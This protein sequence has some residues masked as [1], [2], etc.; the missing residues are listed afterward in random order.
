ME[1]HWLR[2]WLE[3]PWVVRRL[4]ALLRGKEEIESQER[5]AGESLL[6]ETLWHLFEHPGLVGELFFQLARHV[7]KMALTVITTHTYTIDNPKCKNG[8]RGGDKN[9]LHYIRYFSFTPC[10]MIVDGHTSLQKR[11]L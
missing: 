4:V 1:P 5:G 2:D 7:D 11:K 3:D 9:C 6:G 10:W 8:A